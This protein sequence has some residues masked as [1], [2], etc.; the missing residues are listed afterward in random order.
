[1]FYCQ[2]VGVALR[3]QWAH[4]IDLL[5]V[6]V[7]EDQLVVGGINDGGSVGAG[8][9]VGSG[10]GS[11]GPQHSGLGAKCD[12]LTLAQGTWGKE[13]RVKHKQV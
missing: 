6:D 7:G 12:F 10:Q 13:T 2:P 8:E 11:E 3:V 9:D 4:V 1:M 5:E